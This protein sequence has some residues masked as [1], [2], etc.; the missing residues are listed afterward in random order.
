ME[1]IYEVS[2]P[3]FVLPFVKVKATN[4]KEAKEKAFEEI[5][6]RLDILFP[7]NDNRTMS[8]M[9]VDDPDFK[10]EETKTAE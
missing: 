3:M 10:V 7:K 9:G 8:D 2:V 5:K 6:Y 1:K 4:E